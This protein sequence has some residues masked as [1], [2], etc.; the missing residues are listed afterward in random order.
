MT[1][2]IAVLALATGLLAWHYAGYPL[3]LSW[4]AS[5][6][7]HGETPAF[8]DDEFPPVSI[9]VIAYNEADGIADRVRDC[10]AVNYPT[11]KLEVVVAS[12]GSTDDT[13]V[14]A[15][16][17]DGPIE[18]FDNPDGSKSETRN[19]AVKRASNDIILFTDA[20]TRY[21]PSCVRRLVDRYADPDVGAVCGTLVTG[22][23]DDGAIGRGMSV[24]WR[25]EYFMREQQ[26]RLG[27]LVKMSGANMSMRRSFY[28]DVPDTMDID[29][30]AGLNAIRQGGKSLHA[31]QAV[32]TEEF[33][34]DPDAE[35]SVRRRLTIRALSALGYHRA[36][37]NP[38]NGAF[39]AIHTLSYWLLRYLVP[40]LLVLFAV[41]SVAV[42]VSTPVVWGLVAGQALFYTVA[43]F[44]YLVPSS[45]SVPPVSVVFSYCWAN[46][47]VAMGLAAFCTGTR[48]RSY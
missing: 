37:F 27:K 14:E 29:Q 12:D 45:R 39:L 7:D 15:Q 40:V 23:F 36:V 10:L 31:G 3:V 5:R 18:V 26:G 21:E 22:S 20:D 41:A 34:T 11:E 9:I 48:L 16:A 33:P 43:A 25:W 19:M 28:R 46:L 17:V 42:A 2:W 1:L 38:R 8:D 6:T 30:V 44:G 24:Y 4:L 32:A 35:L 13:V 47:G